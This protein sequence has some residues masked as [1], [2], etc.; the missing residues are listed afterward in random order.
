VNTPALHV[1][2]IRKS[3]RDFTALNDISFTIQ[4]GSITALIGPNGAGKTTLLKIITGLIPHD[5]GEISSPLALPG[6]TWFSYLPEECGLYERMKVADVIIYFARLGGLTLAEAKSELPNWLERMKLT[7]KRHH[8]LIELSKGNQQKVKLITALIS[9]PPVLILDEPFTGLDGEGSDL[10]RLALLDARTRGTTL[11]ISSHR[12][13]QM[14]IIADHVVVIS[15]GQIALDAPLKEARRLYQHNRIAVTFT[16]APPSLND[17]PH[18]LELEWDE[19]TAYLTITPG[20]NPG[21]VLKSLIDHHFDV[22]SFSRP[23]TNLG[24]IFS[25]ITQNSKAEK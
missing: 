3:F 16:H 11:L 25:K 8:R 24:E 10:L 4:Q 22:E 6:K 5:G 7:P 1:H 13:D 23:N 2:G 15:S 20:I 17:I 9:H 19:G 12:L 21:E 18:V 14:D